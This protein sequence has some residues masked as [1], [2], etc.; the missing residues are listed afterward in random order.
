MPLGDLRVHTSAQVMRPLEG[1]SGHPH[2]LPPGVCFS[3]V[4]LRGEGCAQEPGLERKDPELDA[5]ALSLSSV[6][7]ASRIWKIPTSVS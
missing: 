1:L 6:G 4:C 3:G 2:L 7:A 5:R